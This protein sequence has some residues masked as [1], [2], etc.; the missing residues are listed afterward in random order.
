MPLKP[1]MAA[2]SHLGLKGLLEHLRFEAAAYLFY[3]YARKKSRD[4]FYFS[5]DP[6]GQG[7]LRSRGIAEISEGLLTSEGLLDL[8]GILGS[9]G[10]TDL[11]GITVIPRDTE[12]RRDY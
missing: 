6:C 7:L 1:G 9:G 12:I 4:A 3:Y 2:V 10:I 5:E 11:R 8:R